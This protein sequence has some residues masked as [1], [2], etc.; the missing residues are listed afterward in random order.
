MTF[1]TTYDSSKSIDEY[2]AEYRKE[3]KQVEYVLSTSTWQ[4]LP[5]FVIK[6][7]ENYLEYLK[8]DLEILEKVKL[9]S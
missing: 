9:P 1:T 2:I 8:K 6:K 3:I 4:T 5:K 7:A